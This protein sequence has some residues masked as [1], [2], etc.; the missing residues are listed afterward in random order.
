MMNP[1]GDNFYCASKTKPSQVTKSISKA[2][3]QIVELQCIES[4]SPKH[5]ARLLE[6]HRAREDTKLLTVQ[7]LYALENYNGLPFRLYVTQILIQELVLFS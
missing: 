2:N 6:L 1:D 5:I 4:P 7:I 3:S